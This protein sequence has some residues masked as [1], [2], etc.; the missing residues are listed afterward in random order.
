[1]L[2]CGLQYEGTLRNADIN[3]QGI[4]DASMY[5][6]LAEDYYNPKS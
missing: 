3:N 2:T 6:L 1:M 5:G 4:C